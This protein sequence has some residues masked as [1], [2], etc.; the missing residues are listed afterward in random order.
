MESLINDIRYGVRGLLKR[1]AFTAIAIITLALGIGANTA[2]FSLVNAVLLRALPYHD[3]DRL[4]MVWED[5][6]FAGFP[7][8]TPAPANFADWRSQNQS[9]EGMA[10]ITTKSFNLT[11][12][13]EPEKL[14]ANTATANFFSLLG[15]QPMLGRGFVPEDDNPPGNR[16]AVVSYELWQR[17]LGG[18]A[19]IIGKDILLNGEKY[20]V[21]GV[22]PAGFQFLDQEVNLW[23]PAAFD[24]EELS[25][26]GGHYLTVFARLK[27]GVTLS[28]ARADI[29]GIMQ[30][31]AHDHPG[32]AERLGSSVVPIRDEL[33]GDVRRPLIILLGAVGFVLLIAC[34]NIASLLLSRTAARRKEI[35]LRAALGA[36]RARIIR[37]LLTESVVLAGAGGI[38]GMFCAFWS[39]AFL[40]QLIP[41]SMALGTEL[42]LDWQVLAFTLVI[43]FATG[44]FFGLVP[45]LQ[46]SRL[47]LNEALKQGSGRSGIGPGS[48]RLRNVLVSSEVALALVLLIGASLLLK[49]FFSLRHQYSALAGANV[50]TLRTQL[51][52]T[53][54]ADVS[55]RAAF[56]SQVL[57]RV[58]TL[59]GVIS[60]GYTT[61]IPLVWK[62]GTSGFFPEGRSYAEAV[63]SGLSFDSNHRQISAGYLKTMGIGILRGRSFA[64]ADNEQAQ[65]VAIVN[66]TMARQYWP[67]EEVL[68]KRFTLGDPDKPLPW[69]TIVG[70]A[71]DVHQMGPDLPVKAEMYFPYR[72]EIVHFYAPRDLVIR[73]TTDPLSIAA[74]V[75]REIKA[76]DVDQPV[77]NVRTLDDVLSKEIAPRRIAM[78]LLM[79][80]AGLALVL[81]SIGIYGVLSYFVTQSTPEIGV[82]VALGARQIDV[83]KLVVG[84]G[85]KLAL[86]GLAVGLAAALL[87]TRLMASLLFGVSATDVTS[88]VGVSVLLLLVALLACY[89]PARRATKVDPLVALRYE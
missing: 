68:G 6:S 37:Q 51:P 48:N 28:Q 38:L 44:I 2:I 39:F 74:A 17:V 64:E 76:V 1:P 57:D 43:S 60:A 31:I 15:V 27:P 58:Q 69:V 46:A 18:E 23:V 45:A 33:A 65:P 83:L 22:T 75:R 32:Q 41:E 63:A 13:G 19:S 30:R 81:A 77:S 87:L 12:Q 7:K 26:R 50:L 73:T 8:N 14:E 11:G 82:R 84:R 55:Q 25:N 71:A 9:F 59:P 24:A 21:I 52:R 62:G 16:V 88:F 5:A 42:T 34:A 72:Q 85:M 80:F 61:T 29:R 47:N 3:A 36:G 20:T 53:K 10:A 70:V 35:A 49:T 54:Y 4:V 40:R 56:Y 67:G 66:E 89:I 86:A 78:T 79:T